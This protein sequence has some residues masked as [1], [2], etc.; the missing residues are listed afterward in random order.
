MSWSSRFRRGAALLVA[1]AAL[2]ACGFKPLYGPGGGAALEADLGRVEIKP[3]AGRL[4]V[5]MYN[6]LRDRIA[7]RGIAEAPDYSLSV[8]LETNSVGLITE[9]NSRIRRF[10]LVV[11]ARYN[12]VDA[13]TD[14]VA[15]T[16]EASSAASY[17]VLD[18]ASFA[19]LSAEQDAER[20][21]ARTVGDQIA[22]EIATFLHRKRREQA[23]GET[24]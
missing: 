12:L 15:L 10:D 18:N 17:N 3:M 24:P 20:Q 5:E 1:G 23:A 2:A 14:A 7:P 4:G 19:T 11:T 8:A 22:L 9:Q 13:E 6:R 16:G 21:A